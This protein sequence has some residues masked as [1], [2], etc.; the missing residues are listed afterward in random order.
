MVKSSPVATHIMIQLECLIEFL[1]VT[2]NSPA[3][4]SDGDNVVS[5][6]SPGWLLAFFAIMGGIH[7]T[8]F[9]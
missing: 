2:L 4:L 3:F 1:I 7:A 8:E 9:S 6:V 5:G